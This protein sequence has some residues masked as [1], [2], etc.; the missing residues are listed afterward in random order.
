MK[1]IKQIV[2]IITIIVLVGL[3]VLTF[4]FALSGRPDWW[5]LFVASVAATVLIPLTIWLLLRMI[6]KFKGED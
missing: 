2:A 6:A 1:K 5:N 4:I 3:Y